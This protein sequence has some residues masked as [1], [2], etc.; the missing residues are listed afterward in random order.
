M[1]SNLDN[2]LIKLLQKQSRDLNDKTIVE[3]TDDIGFEKV[4]FG[5]VR[6]TNSPYNPYDGL[7]TLSEVDGK[8][9]LVR[10]SD[11][12]FDYKTSG[13][14]VVASDY[15]NCNVTLAY[16]NI[17]IHRFSSEDFG[18]SG[19]DISIFKSAILDKAGSDEKFVKELLSEQPVTKKESLINTFPELKKYI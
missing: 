18:F 10:A 13:D 2:I 11:P 4:A 6:I 9:F 16:K 5:M 15:D 8:K 17:P 19:E 3:V 7:W 1:S 12:K 14:W